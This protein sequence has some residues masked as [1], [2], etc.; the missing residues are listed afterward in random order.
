MTKKTKT[1]SQKA[2]LEVTKKKISVLSRSSQKALVGGRL[3]AY[4]LHRNKAK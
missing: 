2:P 4:P 1:P 3:G